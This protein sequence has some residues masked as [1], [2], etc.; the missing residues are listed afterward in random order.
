MTDRYEDSVALDDVN[1]KFTLEEWAFLDRTQKKLYRDVMQ[2][3]F[4]NLASIACILEEKWEDHD[5]DDQH[6]NHGTNLRLCPASQEY[7]QNHH[8]LLDCVV[9]GVG[10]TVVQNSTSRIQCSLDSPA[11]PRMSIGQQMEAIMVENVP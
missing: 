2:E 7:P 5:N 1:V 3:T 6:K 11:S 10:F 8:R 9:Q 4:R